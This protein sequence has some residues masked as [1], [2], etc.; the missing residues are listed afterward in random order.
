[1]TKNDNGDR[2]PSTNPDKPVVTPA[3]D[4]NDL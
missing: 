3:D 2:T 1:M 4:G